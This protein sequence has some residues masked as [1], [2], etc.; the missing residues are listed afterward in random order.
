MEAEKRTIWKAARQRR[1]EQ[2]VKIPPAPLQA[3]ASRSRIGETPRSRQ[4]SCAITKP[5][6]AKLRSHVATGKFRTGTVAVAVP[7]Q[8]IGEEEQ[9]ERRR[10]RYGAAL[11]FAGEELGRKAEKRN[12]PYACTRNHSFAQEKQRSEQF[13]KLLIQLGKRRIE[14]FGKLRDRRNTPFQARSRAITKPYHSSVCHPSSRSR[15]FAIM[16][17]ACVPSQSINHATSFV[18]RPGH[19]DV[20]QAIDTRRTMRPD[21]VTCS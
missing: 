20:D 3:P 21:G 16:H 18:R 11:L 6:Y 8:K 12:C 1:R 14:R 2:F 15:L 9:R 17:D 5:P 7:C 10:R 4:K 19:D 13:G